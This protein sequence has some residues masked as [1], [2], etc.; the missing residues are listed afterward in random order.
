MIAP[1]STGANDSI[2]A[3]VCEGFGGPDVLK[4]V[5]LARPAPKPGELL[6][7][8]LASTITAADRR[9]RSMEVRRGLGTLGR[10]ALGWKAPRNPVLGATLAGVVQALA[11]GAKG[12]VP[13]EAAFGISEFR[14][15][16]HA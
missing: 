15:G 10:L 5:Q 13:G 16:G 12:F 9:V 11:S 14:M 4:L 7:R 6:V 2:T 1:V 8:V 3:L